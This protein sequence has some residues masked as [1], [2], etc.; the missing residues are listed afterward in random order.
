MTGVQKC[1]LPIYPSED[2]GRK[3]K[4][5]EGHVGHAFHSNITLITPDG[6]EPHVRDLMAAGANTKLYDAEV[7]RSYVSQPISQPD[8]TARPFGVIV[9]TSDH[10]DRFNKANALVLHHASIILATAIQVGYDSS[11]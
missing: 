4:D 1:A 9:A 7:Y 11:R 6:T 2:E 5:G 3:W 10:P 8:G